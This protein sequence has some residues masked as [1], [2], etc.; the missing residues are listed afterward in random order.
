MNS[1]LKQ[2][3]EQK[4]D[5]CWEPGERWRVLQATIAWVDSQQKVPRNSPTGCLKAEQRLLGK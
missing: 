4:R 1:K 2:A 3:E 5:A